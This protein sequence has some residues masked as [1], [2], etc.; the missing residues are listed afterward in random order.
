MLLK[1]LGAINLTEQPNNLNS[2]KNE[3]EMNIGKLNYEL[4]YNENIFIYTLQN[5]FHS[6]DRSKVFISKRMGIKR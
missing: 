1:I 6:N 2:S 3:E 4:N 5:S